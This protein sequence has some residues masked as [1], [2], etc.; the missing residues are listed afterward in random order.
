MATPEGAGNHRIAEWFGLE[1][2][3]KPTQPNPC[4]GQ[5]CPPP[6]QAAQGPIQPG[7]ERLQGW[8]T[9]ASLGSCA[10]AS[11]PSDFPL[12][13][14]LHYPS[15]SLKSFPLVPS[16]SDFYKVHLPPL[17]KLPLSTRRLQ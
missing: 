2:A 6:A 17:Y 13:S 5:G 11:L 10:S 9:T 15:S 1:G 14:H 16:L 4:R 12:I 7:L 8:G 3:S